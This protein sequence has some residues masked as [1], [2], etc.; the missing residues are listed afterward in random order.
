MNK[1]KLTTTLRTN[2]LNLMLS[3]LVRLK[4]AKGILFK[5]FFICIFYFNAEQIM[6]FKE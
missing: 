3:T 1:K 4:R 5:Y 2:V 6:V